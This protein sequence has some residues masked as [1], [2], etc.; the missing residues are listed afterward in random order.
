[1]Y[2]STAA[3]KWSCEPIKPA[4]ITICGGS[5]QLPFFRSGNRGENRR[6]S[7]SDG[8]EANEVAG[9]LEVV[10]AIEVAKHV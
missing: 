6:H 5:F 3:Q 1:M 2:T 9:L 10:H 7:E 8:I 4:M